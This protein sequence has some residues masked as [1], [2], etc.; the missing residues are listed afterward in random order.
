VLIGYNQITLERTTD[1]QTSGW[2]WSYNGKTRKKSETVFNSGLIGI[3]AIV[4]LTKDKNIGIRGDARLLFTDAEF[5]RDDGLRIT[6]SGP[7]LA[8]TAT[9]YWNIYKGLNLQVGAKGQ[10]MNGGNAGAYGKAGAFASLG[11]AY[12]F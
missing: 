8:A 3:G 7:G 4:P 9:G 1:I 6:G 11:Y 2:I 10:L 5:T 12:R